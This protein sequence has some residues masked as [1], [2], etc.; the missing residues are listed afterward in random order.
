MDVHVLFAQR[1]ERYDGE[2]A[3]EALT[4]VDSFTL[5]ETALEIIEKEYIEDWNRRFADESTSFDRV[6]VAWDW[7]KVV[8]DIDPQQLRNHLLNPLAVSGHVTLSPSDKAHPSYGGIT[9]TP[10]RA[11]GRIVDSEIRD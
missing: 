11:P 3:P 1:E 7:V 4:L 10:G 8:L 2:Y 9:V 5:E 6:F